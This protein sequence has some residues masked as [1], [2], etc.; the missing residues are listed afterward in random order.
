M[1]ETKADRLNELFCGALPSVSKEPLSRLPRGLFAYV[2][3]VSGPQ[4]VRLILLTALVFPLSMAPL[5]LQRWIVDKAILKGD[6]A[7]L[8]QLALL[9]L[10]V[11]LVHGGLKFCRNVYQGRVG[12]GVV[13]RLRRRMVDYPLGRKQQSG[14]HVSMVA[15]E[16][17]AIGGFVSESLAFPLLQGGIIATVAGYMLWVNPLIALVALGVMLPTL[18]V[19][20]LVQRRIDTLVEDKTGLLRELGDDIVEEDSQAGDAE[21][22]A[23]QSIYDVRIRIFYYKFFLKFFNNFVGH[24]GPL[25]VLLFGGWLVIRGE[26]E[27][28]TIVAFISGFEKIVDPAR[29]LLAYYR[30]QSQMRVQYRL[31]RKAFTE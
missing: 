10:A 3:R 19:A 8:W 15:A 16:A 14:A 28:G 11:L 2:W 7:L 29:Q 5:E 27:L 1:S 21:K 9:Y 4:Q 30:R 20:P 25:G 22:S 24:I 18:V 26:A 6:W 13:R 23:I 31:V 17:D 12:E